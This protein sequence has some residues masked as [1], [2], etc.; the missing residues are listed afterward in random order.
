M[1]DRDTLRTA[2]LFGKPYWWEWMP[3]GRLTLRKAAW[4]SSRRNP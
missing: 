1:R 3:D 4:M 2:W